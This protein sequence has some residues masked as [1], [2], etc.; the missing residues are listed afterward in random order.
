MNIVIY[1]GT[2]TRALQ[3][4]TTGSVFKP[5]QVDIT[6]LAPGHYSTELEYVGQTYK[7]QLIVR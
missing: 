3:I 1:T 7:S 4:S 2:G 6:S 5:I